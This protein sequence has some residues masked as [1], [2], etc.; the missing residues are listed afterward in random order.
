[1]KK[2]IFLFLIINYQLSIYNC[3]SQITDN[4]SDGDFTKNPVWSGEDSIFVIEN[5]SLRSNSHT[6]NTS[7]YLNTPSTLATDVQ[8]EFYIK[9]LFQTSSKNYVDVFLVSDKN[10][11]KSPL[12]GY[13]VRIGDTDDEVSLY[14]K[15]G[16]T[17]TRIINGTDKTT[18]KTT[19]VLKI[20]VTRNTS[21][22]WT[23]SC[24]YSGTGN[25]YFTEGTFT[26]ATFTTSSFFGVFIKQ[27][28]AS[29]FQKHFFDDFYVGPII[30][31]KTP[32]TIDTVRV[33][34]NT[35]IDVL[36]SENIDTA[37]A[38]NLTN[39]FVNNGIGNPTTALIDAIDKRLVHLIFVNS[40]ADGIKNTITINNIKDLNANVINPSSTYDF[41]YNKP[42]F[43][44]FK[45]IIINEIMAA[46]HPVV[47][48]PDVEYLELY[49]KTKK[50]IV[51]NGWDIKLKTTNKP[52]PNVVIPADSFLILTSYDSLN[53]YGIVAKMSSM[54]LTDGG[55]S[56]QLLDDKNNIIDSLT[57]SDA[58]YQNAKKKSGGWSL[59]LINPSAANNCSAA[60]NWRAS[61]DAK[62]GTPGKPNSIYSI[63]IDTISPVITDVSVVDS[64]HINICF[65]EFIDAASLT[66]LAN[67]SINDTAKK[68]I[69]VTANELGN[70][71]V[72]SLSSSLTNSSNY[73][74]TIKNISDCAGN[75]IPAKDFSLV[76]YIAKP[77]D[78]VI[79]EIMADPTPIVGLPDIEY[80]ELYNKTIYP[81]NINGW[82]FQYGKTKK[83]LPNAVIPPDGYL[84]LVN[85]ADFSL[86]SSYGNVVAVEGL[87]KDALTN[88]GTTLTLFDKNK[89]IIHSI[90]YSDSWFQNSKKKDGGWSLEQ[91]DPLNP[92]GGADNWK[93]STD[94]NG[95][96]PSKKNS[97]YASNLD[98]KSPQLLRAAV[99]DSVTIRLIFDE[100]I[101]TNTFLDSTI[102]NIDNGI[103]NPKK[104]IPVSP[105]FS[106][107]VLTLKTYLTKNIN[108]TVTI[109]NN[110]LDCVGNP[111]GAEN[112]AKFAIPD[113]IDSLD[114]IINEVLFYPNDGGADF[115]EIY[116]NSK[117]ILDLKDLQISSVDTSIIPNILTTVYQIDSVGYLMFPEEYLVLTINPKT[118]KEQYP[119]SNDKNPKG[120]IEMDGMPT[121]SQKGGRIV[122]SKK[123]QQQIDR[124]NFF[125]KMHFVLLN[126]FKGVSLERLDFNR[127]TNDA[128]NWHSA[129]EAVG[130]ATPAYL[131]SQANRADTT[132]NPFTISP[133]IFS[134]DNDGIDDV[135]NIHYKFEQPGNTGSITIFDANGRSVK[136]LIR[137]ELLGITG[138]FSWDGINEQK[139]KCNIGIYIIFF[140]TFDLKGNVKKYKK[141]AVLGGKL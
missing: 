69:L 137:N 94:K 117:K 52:L 19:N 33:V 114:I 138:T 121:F 30:V 123:N 40:F 108:Y 95:G 109:K 103:G 10:D 132:G 112:S 8:W 130:Y 53:T 97:V 31:D 4:F 102:Y 36:F 92:C 72:I 89:N 129:S 66:T 7:F 128:T 22:L 131:N 74:L 71:A 135:L 5:N 122:L 113:K 50:N 17:N 119:L 93:A 61:N 83:T 57:Y 124:F 136:Y 139:E 26:D 55:M 77:F 35:E 67:Y 106:A 64:T 115:V 25:S 18:D 87:A 110:L 140:E 45:D 9:L 118:V 84:V 2:L 111:V 120:F 14:K 105:D 39:Y 107:V 28:T 3:F 91:I 133:Q 79:N 11:L 21:N 49:N 80:T 29:F 32:P 34:S 38:K 41:I 75:N 76:Y 43:V 125:E 37:D 48:F 27:S 51:L 63:A 12:N 126:S 78:I 20:K 47:G 134:P 68:I 44:N 88:D 98:T 82:E 90:T 46:P 100:P 60:A 81:I 58:W 116:N 85:P 59:E 104:I 13:F 62:G 86:L 127:P 24:D 141:V 16:T 99:Q 56:V 54:T 23:L 6:E 73:T 15:S 65:N 101:K 1:M 42:F 96:T 70:C